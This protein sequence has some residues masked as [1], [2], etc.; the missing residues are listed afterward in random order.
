[1]DPYYTSI[2]ATHIHSYCAH[3]MVDNKMYEEDP[4]KSK[5]AFEECFGNIF[6]NIVIIN[7]GTQA[8][9]KDKEGR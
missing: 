1:M 4:N 2:I 6:N 5:N 3:Y 9:Y 7:K 8:F